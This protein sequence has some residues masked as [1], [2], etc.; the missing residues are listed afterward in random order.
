MNRTT[1]TLHKWLGI[2]TGFVF[3]GWLVSGIVMELPYGVR[4]AYS[5]PY[6][7]ADWGGVVV[8]PAEAALAATDG[9]ATTVDQVE[10]RRIGERFVYRVVAGEVTRLIDAS[11]SELVTVDRE[12]A[13]TLAR[14][15]FDAGAEIAE[16]R[17]ME[18]R[19]PSYAYGPLPAWR[20]DWVDGR[21][22]VSYVSVG[23]GSILRADHV[24]RTR[25]AIESLH[26]FAFLDAL[27]VGETRQP[28]L[29]AASIVSLVTVATGYL[30]TILLSAWYRRR[31]GARG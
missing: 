31:R 16:V 28:I 20:V 30:L 24:T 4:S 18:D 9:R 11:T 26:T 12:T 10:L 3:L 13:V 8:S 6:G 25:A 29:I 22:S 23:D 14:T 7:T 27:R 15:E 21:G 5:G 17:L 2:A 1:R 19:E